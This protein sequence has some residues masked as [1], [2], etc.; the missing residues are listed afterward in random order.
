LEF[1]AR[2][3]SRSGFRF[4]FVFGFFFGG[5]EFFFRV[6]KNLLEDFCCLFGGDLAFG[7]RFFDH[8]FDGLLYRLALFGESGFR[9]TV[10]VVCVTESG[11]GVAAVSGPRPEG[12][13][14]G[15]QSLLLFRAQGVERCRVDPFAV[16]E[17]LERHSVYLRFKF[18]QKGFCVG[19]PCQCYKRTLR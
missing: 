18:R 4:L 1:S 2:D 10:F 19:V 14:F 6:G 16:Q 7:D 17:F 12:V 9:V 5:F 15:A 3:L 13:K 8:L 11:P